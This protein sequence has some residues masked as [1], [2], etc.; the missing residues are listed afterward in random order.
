MTALLASDDDFARV[1]SSRAR[2]VVAA[3]AAL[4]AADAL[5]VIAML[6]WL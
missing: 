3:I 5:S 1:T 6:F 2:F 4:L